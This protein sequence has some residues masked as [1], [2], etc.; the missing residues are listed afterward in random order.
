NI[1]MTF[2][3]L[4]VN[5]WTIAGVFLPEGARFAEPAEFRSLIDRLGGFPISAMQWTR[6]HDRA[7]LFEEA[8]E[9]TRQ[10]SRVFSAALRGERWDIALVGFMAPDR[11]QHVGMDLLDAAH[12][13]HAAGDG[14]DRLLTV[15]AELD[16]TLGEV[17]D[18]AAAETVVLAS[19][20]GFRSVWR[21]VVPNA[22]LREL[23]Y[24]RPRR[25][26][27]HAPR[28]VRPLRT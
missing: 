16:R 1:P 12:P 6:A 7:V 8:R 13:H 2:P 9:V 14:P 28:L 18:A 11:V 4:P 5:G 22:L 19:D 23:G 24:F 15:Y 25:L 26:A 10:T 27:W 20:H 17:L 21:D 3:V